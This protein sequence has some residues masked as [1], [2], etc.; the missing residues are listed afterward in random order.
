M[1][2]EEAFHNGNLAVGDELCTGSRRKALDR[3]PGLE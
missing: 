2:T 1:S 3:L